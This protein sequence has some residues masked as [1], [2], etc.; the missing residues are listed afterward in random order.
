MQLNFGAGDVFAQV[1][2]NQL[3]VAVPLATPLRV[4]G[5]QEFSLD[6]SGDL[7]EYHGQNRYALAIAMGKVKTTGKM[8][9][10]IIDGR[11]LNTLFFGG[12]ITTGTIKSIYADVAGIT[13]AAT[14]ATVP[15]TDT[16]IA[17]AAWV[18]DLGV[19]NASG[20]ALV[21]VA[22][23]P[24]TGQYSVTGGT[25]T[26]AAADV[27]TTVYRSYTYSAAVATARRIALDNVTMG[28]APRMKLFYQGTFD[29]RRCLLELNSITS[30]KLGLFSS[31]ND[32]FSVPEI[33]FSA[34]VDDAGFSLGSIF[35]TE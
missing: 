16:G 4:A 17:G 9:G 11:S 26:F 31:K 3:G 30:T 32:D 35:T 21:K 5:L 14:V 1:T 10:A 18:D 25:Y 12:T 33:D 15:A 6:F 24:V 7:K 13:V 27:G 22:S 2:R 29:N 19:V 23:A 20:I 28:V 34:S 8:K